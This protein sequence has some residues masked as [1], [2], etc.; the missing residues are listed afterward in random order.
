M[1]K[2]FFTFCLLFSF[3]FSLQTLAMS[4]MNFSI[5]INESKSKVISAGEHKVP[6]S[7]IAELLSESPV[8]VIGEAEFGV[9][10]MYTDFVHYLTLKFDGLFTS[11]NVPVEIILENMTVYGDSIFLKVFLRKMREKKSF[12]KLTISLSD[13]KVR[14][15]NEFHDTYQIVLTPKTSNFC[16]YYQ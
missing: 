2:M 4:Y 5:D 9:K 16:H 3:G 7:E 14:A 13:Y 6:L 1:K 8:E 10:N 15:P 11:S 12:C